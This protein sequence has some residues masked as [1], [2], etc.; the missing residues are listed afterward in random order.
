M[1][2]E[3]KNNAADMDSGKNSLALMK[4]KNIKLIFSNICLKKK[5]TV[6]YN[7]S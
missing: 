4:K 2:K 7:V 6:Y 5:Q 1:S 3:T